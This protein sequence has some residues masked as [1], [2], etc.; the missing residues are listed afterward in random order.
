MDSMALIKIRL[1]GSPARI[2]PFGA[3][4]SGLT[5]SVRGSAFWGLPFGA[6]TLR[7]SAFWGL[8]S[9]FFLPLG[10]HALRHSA[11]RGLGLALRGSLRS[12]SGLGIG[13]IL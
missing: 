11:F 13:P 6:H 9:G 4:L 3:C 5:P 1:W 7:G 8:P 2:Q 10:A 12:L